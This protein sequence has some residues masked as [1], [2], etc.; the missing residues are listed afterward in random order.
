[1]EEGKGRT[2]RLPEGLASLKE[3][4]G[5]GEPLRIIAVEIKR[6]VWQDHLLREPGGSP[7]RK[8]KGAV[9]DLD[10]KGTVPADWGSIR[11]SCLEGV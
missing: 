3:G 2:N 10:L 4:H 11:E 9:A 7:G 1:M 6:E 5:G 8:E